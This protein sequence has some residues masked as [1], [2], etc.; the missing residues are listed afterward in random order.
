[1]DT[2]KPAPQ[3]VHTTLEKAPT[4]TEN[5]PAAQLVRE[6][7]LTL[8][9]YVPAAQLMHADAGGVETKRPTA[10]L[11]HS[12]VDVAAF[13]LVY[14]PGGQSSQLADPLRPENVPEAHSVQLVEAASAV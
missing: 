13:P 5:A 14:V 4:A 12:L 7:D 10:Q 1:V 2:N 9:A 8:T 11:V 3:R 6:A